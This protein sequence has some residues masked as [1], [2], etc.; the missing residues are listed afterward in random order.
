M[1]RR[2]TDRRFHLD[3]ISLNARA[4]K[5]VVHDRSHI[6]RCHFSLERIFGYKIEI[7]IS[8]ENQFYFVFLNVEDDEE[9]DE[10]CANGVD[11]GGYDEDDDDGFRRDPP[12]HLPLHPLHRHHHRHGLHRHRYDDL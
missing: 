2:K 3:F 5:I 6:I 9:Y 4:T 10:D 7:G 12:L 1:V 11:D 8:M